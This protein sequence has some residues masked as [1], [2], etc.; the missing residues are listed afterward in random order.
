MVRGPGPLAGARD[1]ERRARADPAPDFTLNNPNRVRSLISTFCAGNQVHF[2]AAD[3]EG[4][5]FLGDAVIELDSLNPQVAARLASCLNRWR[6]FDQGRQALMGAQ[7]E[8]IAARP[9]L[10]KD[11]AEIVGRALKA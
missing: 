3:G 4:Y 10:S 8:R 9:G 2:N 11:V 7:L 1:A 5:R 6:R